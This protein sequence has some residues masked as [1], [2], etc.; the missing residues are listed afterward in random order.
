MSLA[1]YYGIP[2]NDGENLFWGSFIDLPFRGPR[3]P[4]LKESE[5]E[6]VDVVH[7]FYAEEF[8]LTDSEQAARYRTI[9]D[10]II[11]GWYVCCYR[12]VFRDE[13]GK[14]RV[15]LEWTQRYAYYPQKAGTT[16]LG[17]S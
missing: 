6:N 8:D 17:K 12:D 14:R 11:N 13:N 4:L 9:M 3:P 15:Y 16:H 5:I 7:D 2:E 1:K 10:R